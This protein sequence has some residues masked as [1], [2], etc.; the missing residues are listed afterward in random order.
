MLFVAL[1]RLRPGTDP[2]EPMERRLEWQH[3]EGS[4]VV[5]EYWLQT[6][7]PEVILVVQTDS[8][9]SIMGMIAAWGDLYEITVAPAVAAEEGLQI[10]KQM[11]EQQK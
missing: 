4:E 5:A 11:M 1:C 3:P 6:S 8:V 2:K 10:V 9:A 7:D